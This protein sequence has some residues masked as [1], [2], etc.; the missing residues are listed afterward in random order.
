MPH[1]SRVRF[2][3][4]TFLFPHFL[5]TG[6]CL[7]CLTWSVR[8]LTGRLLLFFSHARFCSE[9]RYITV[10]KQ[11]MFTGRQQRDGVS[12]LPFLVSGLFTVTSGRRVT[13]DG[14][15]SSAARAPPDACELVHDD[16]DADGE[17][18]DDGYD[19]DIEAAKVGRGFHFDW[20]SYHSVWNN[21]PFDVAVV[22]LFA[23]YAALYARISGQVLSTVPPPMTLETGL[24]IAEQAARFVSQYVT[25]VLGELQST[26]VHK[27]LRHVMDAIKWH[28]NLQ[29]GN[30]AE[31]ESEHK[32]DKPFYFRTNKH[33]LNFTKQLVVFSQGS[34]EVL[35]KLNA[36]ENAVLGPRDGEPSGSRGRDAAALDDDAD[37]T[38]AEAEGAPAAAEQRTP[39]PGVAVAYH[40]A[41]LTVGH[42][43]ALT[44]LAGV[45]RLLGLEDA[46][47]VPVLWCRK[48]AATM[49]CGTPTVQTVR[50]ARSF[51]KRP[52]YDAVQY[53]PSPEQDMVSVGELRVMLRL[54]IGDVAVLCEMEPV[55]PVP[56]CPLA[57]RGCTRLAWRVEPGTTRIA[58]RV[59][60]VESIRRL[61]LVVP[62]FAELSVRKGPFALPPANDADMAERL[63]MRFFVNDLHPW[64]ISKK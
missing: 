43:A 1:P 33:V 16:G 32:R 23:E 17:V 12:V 52:W 24:S 61:L 9:C 36:D 29:H 22:E 53:R 41:K 4:I 6:H 2:L 39:T 13:P 3:H 46:T 31:N 21:T 63:A 8:T 30:T 64:K 57:R 18:A 49:D 27:L 48:I 7:T 19:A 15:D 60:P 55:A 10:E 40:L 20:A 26:K 44:D 42:L 37:E 35:A 54:P 38:S 28:G 47:K 45:G 5:C 59:I 56:G 58:L 51:Y 14:V 62:D 11:A 34:A 25:P 50:A